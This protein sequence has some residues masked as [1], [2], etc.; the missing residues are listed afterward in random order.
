MV[1]KSFIVSY[2]LDP[3]CYTPAEMVV[4][5]EAIAAVMLE[6]VAKIKDNKKKF[7][8]RYAINLI[9]NLKLF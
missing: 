2:T 9:D 5:N 8:Q 6:F 7:L 4:I 3:L 1:L